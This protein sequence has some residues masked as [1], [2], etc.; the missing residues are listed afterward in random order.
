MYH[1][2]P[3]PN[4]KSYSALY[5]NHIIL[6]LTL[7][8]KLTQPIFIVSKNYCILYFEETYYKKIMN[9]YRYLIKIINQ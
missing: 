2:L 6:T 5:I 4:L 1:K 7:F 3:E 8:Y 9:M